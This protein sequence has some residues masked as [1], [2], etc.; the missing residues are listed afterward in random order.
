MSFIGSV[1]HVSIVI[2][3][4]NEAD[5][6]ASLLSALNKT[7]TINKFELIVVDGGSTDDSFA[8]AQK[9]A[10]IVIQTRKGR[11]I[12]Q[13]AGAK[14]ASGNSLWFLHADSQLDFKKVDFY[15]KAIN[16]IKWGVF[17]IKLSGKPK[18]F[19][20]IEWFI[21]KRSC[22]TSIATGDQGIFV[23]TGFFNEIGGFPVQ[24]LM[25]DI[26]ISKKLKKHTRLTCINHL[27][28]ITSSRKW[29]G[30]GIWKT[31]FLMWKLRFLYFIG[32]SPKNLAKQYYR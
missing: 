16:S 24:D 32:I 23:Q 12:Q 3:V 4:L 8:T 30:E 2:P 20:V 19:R 15:L 21:N 6:I 9:Y 5:R 10:D 14:A 22:L 25:E 11:A 26:E 28:I 7:K 27:K 18:I 13:N 31:I 1:K 29:Q 17:S